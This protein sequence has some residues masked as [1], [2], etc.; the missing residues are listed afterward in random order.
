[1]IPLPQFPD[2]SNDFFLLI[3]QVIIMTG[4]IFL[5]A[6]Q[7]TAP[8]LLALFMVDVVLGVMNRMAPA[9]NVTFLGQPV[10]AA[11]GI[12]I[13]LAAFSFILRYS[14]KLFMDMVNDI[15]LIWKIL[16]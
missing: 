16:G 10:K 15:R 9:V 2:L 6:F 12:I 13:Y 11:V 8:V 14:A 4:K 5:I 7:L 3:Q 1:M